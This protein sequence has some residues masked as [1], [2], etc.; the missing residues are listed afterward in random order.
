MLTIETL[1]LLIRPFKMSDLD[2]IHHI[3][4]ID[5]GMETQSHDDREEWLRWSILNEK[6]LEKLYQP[7]YGDRP[8]VLKETNAV[9]GA[10]GFVPCLDHFGQLPYFSTRL[11]K[12]VDREHRTAEVGMYWA[13]ASAHQRKGYAAEAAR[14]MIDWAFKHLKLKR[15][16]ATTKYSNEASIG[17]MRRVGMTVERNP[18]PDPFWM[19]IVGIL[20]NPT[21]GSS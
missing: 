1:R 6:Q 5:L 20:E 12:P 2:A 13:I 15:I 17:V 9:I 3:L 11:N 14:G 16:V 7:P 19:E 21:N 4:D 8:I 10:V 18:Y